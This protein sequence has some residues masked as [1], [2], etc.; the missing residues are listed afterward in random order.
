MKPKIS[1]IILNFNAGE[2]ILENLRLLK[3]TFTKEYDFET[4]VADNGSTDGSFERVKN[5]FIW[6]KVI[7]NKENLGFSKG[8][9]QAV[10]KASGDFILFLNPDMRVEEPE[11]W[12]RLV[13][14]M[15]KDEKIGALGCKIVF[16]DGRYDQDSMRQFPGLWNSFT[17]F[18]GLSKIFKGHYLFDSYHLGYLDPDREHEV[19]A[20]P[21]SFLFVRRQAGED[22]GWWDEDY[23]FYGEDLEFCFDL[24][25]KGWKVIYT[26]KVTVTHYKGY[27]SGIRKETKTITRASLETKKRIAKESVNAM[28]IFYKKHYEGK[29]PSYIN[30]LVYNSLKIMEKRRLRSTQ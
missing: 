6:I 27:S 30:Q 16:A 21:G 1:I 2:L 14:L 15:T 5:E 20:V 13:R 26:P 8:N 11:V 3:K 17:H 22:I 24:K 12:S 7:D 18:A 29:Y 28:R 25:E 19:D 9:N 10:K 4:I 23:F